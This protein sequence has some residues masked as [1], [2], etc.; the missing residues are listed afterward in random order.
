MSS[1]PFFSS[2]CK[3]NDSHKYP[4]PVYLCASDTPIRIDA[5]SPISAI[6]DQVSLDFIQ[7]SVHKKNLHTSPWR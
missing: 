6:I 4:G 1:R 2:P 7:S 5:N 3:S